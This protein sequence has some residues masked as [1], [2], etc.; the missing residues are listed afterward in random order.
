MSVDIFITLIILLKS[1]ETGCCKQINSYPFLSIFRTDSFMI[2]SSLIN[3]IRS[4][5]DKYSNNFS[6]LSSTDTQMVS[7]LFDNSIISFSKYNLNI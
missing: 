6:Y 3:S 1:Y 2:K 7:K 4:S 5:F